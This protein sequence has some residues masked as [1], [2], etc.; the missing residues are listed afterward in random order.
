MFGVDVCSRW[1]SDLETLAPDIRE[2]RQLRLRAAR[3]Q[4]DGRESV[5]NEDCP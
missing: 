5:W 1:L 2:L 3:C 4:N